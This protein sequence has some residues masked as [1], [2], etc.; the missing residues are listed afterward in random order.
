M[1]NFRRERVALVT[2]GSRG[3]GRAIC[4]ALVADDVIV[5]VH[6]KAQS[7]AAKAVVSQIEAQ[8]GRAIALQADLVN[9]LEVNQ[10]IEQTVQN[11]GDIDILVNN[12]GGMSRGAVEDLSDD[13]WAHAIT[14]NLTSA[15]RCTRA[16]IPHMK[17]QRWGR[18]INI[19]SQSTESGSRNHAHYVAAKSGLLGF[20][21]SLVKELGE[22]GITVNAVSPGRIVTD[23]LRPSI[24]TREEEWLAQTPL[25]RLG[26]P[27]D[28]A[29][30]VAFLA[31]ESAGYITGANLPVNSGLVMG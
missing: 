13:D 23:L 11:I 31:S 14:L 10:L 25:R 16:C 2:G 20:T 22:Y 29:A 15:F 1:S 6:Y 17:Q 30:A 4:Q 24:P 7:D 8:G 28:V 3:I 19:S 9:P 26:Q 21:Y 27:E 5:A 12:A 18:I